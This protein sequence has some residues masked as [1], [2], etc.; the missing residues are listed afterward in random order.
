MTLRP[1]S[2]SLPAN[3]LGI[4]VSRQIL[5][6]SMA[7]FGQLAPGTS[8]QQVDEVVPGAGRVRGEWVRA[9][10]VERDD[11]AIL[12]L[13][14]SGFALC[15]TSTHRRLVSQLSLLTGLSVFSLDYR[16]APRHRFPAA[17]D[18]T[19]RA[20]DWLVAGGLSADRIV[21]AGDSAGGHLALDLALARLRA[22]LPLP[23][24]QVLLSPLADLTMRLGRAREQVRRDPMISADACARLLGHY[25]RDADPQDARLAHVVAAHEQ[26]PPTLIQ[27]GGAEILAADA[28]HLHDQLTASGTSSRLEVWPGQMHVFQAMP[29]LVPEATVALRRAAAFITESLDLASAHTERATA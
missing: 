7:A 18:D 27:A 28:H 15:S 21:V 2:S 4:A 13:H 23:A 10:G 14:G 5:A 16:L 11:A 29:R 1:V 19:E 3:D 25:A 12:Y 6:R 9:A 20:F 8:V 22:G 17:A 26:L 24:A